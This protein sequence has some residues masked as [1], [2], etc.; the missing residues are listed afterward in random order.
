M[1]P[2]D[3]AR[4]VRNHKGLMISERDD[5][6]MGNQGCE[7]IIGNLGASCGNS[8]DQGGFSHVGVSNKTHIGHQFQLELYPARFT[9][10]AGFRM[11]GRLVGGGGETSVSPSA[12]PAAGSYK[13]F[14]L[15]GKILKDL[16]TFSIPDEGTE[17][18]GEKEVRR[19]APFLVF[20]FSVLA[21]FGVILLLVAKVKKSGNLIGGPY[22]H[23]PA[24]STVTTVGSAPGNVFFTAKTEAAVS[25]ISSFDENF[26]FIDKF[27]R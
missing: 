21:S 4:D 18:N 6:Q 23:V 7:R 3:N 12:A 11:A 17:R 15:A 25:S 20:S 9:R 10:A 5:P 1:G 22:N 27:D 14:S 24:F 13:D 16:S 19:A 8:G 2:L 26:C